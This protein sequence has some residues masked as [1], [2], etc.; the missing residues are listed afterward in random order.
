MAVHDA[1]GLQRVVVTGIGAVSCVGVGSAA[2]LAALRERR[3][4]LRRMPAFASLGMRGRVGGPVDAV[5]LPDEPPRKLR[6]FMG[7]PARYAWHAANEAIAQS[8]LVPAQ[9]AQP[10]VGVVIG[11]GAALSEHERALASH[12]AKGIAKLSPFIVPL[13]MSCAPSASLALAYGLRG[14]SYT[15]S[16]ACSSGAHAIGHALDLIRLGRQEVVITGGTDELHPSTAMWFDAMGA[17]STQLDPAHAA[18]PFHRDRDGLVLAAGAGVLVLESLAHAQ[19]RGA[20]VLAE[21][22]GYGSATDADNM[23]ASGSAGIAHAMRSAL[24]GARHSPDYLNA[25]ACG[26]AG[27]LAEWQAIARVFAERQ[28]P[29]PPMSSLK[30]LLGHAPQAAGALDAVACVLMLQHGLLAAGAEIDARDPAFA[31]APLLEANRAAQI[32]SVL[33]T[34]F[35]FGGSCAALLL[36]RCAEAGT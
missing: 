10:S 32:E 11:G 35:G 16:A 34:S 5:A 2:L 17:L 28:T 8:G 24:A 31:A 33:S 13:G 7:A 19:A 15:L 36:R 3:H 1:N 25:H 6:R 12:R 20:R 27:D 22:A 26:T 9:L 18:R 23:V 14:V 4:G 30:G 29:V 21:L